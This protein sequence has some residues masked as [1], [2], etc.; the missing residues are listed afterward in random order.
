M[1][2]LSRICFHFYYRHHLSYFI[3]FCV[4]IC[5]CFLFLFFFI[6]SSFI[7]I[8]Y[9]SI[10]LKVHL[11]S[12]P[13]CRQDQAQEWL[14]KSQFKAHLRRVQLHNRGPWPAFFTPRLF[15]LH[16]LAPNSGCLRPTPTIRELPQACM[17][18]TTHPYHLWPH[19]SLPRM[20]DWKPPICMKSCTVPFRPSMAWQ[21]TPRAQRLAI[22]CCPDQSH[23]PRMTGTSHSRPCT[24]IPV[25]P[26]KPTNL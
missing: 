20:N 22:I 15:L 4:Y 5:I 14:S 24:A 25:R 12:I 17:A 13:N 26:S 1:S 21:T 6:I 18:P 7:L 3:F 2:F 8:C 9:F 11:S 23:L 19:T 10:R 16:Q